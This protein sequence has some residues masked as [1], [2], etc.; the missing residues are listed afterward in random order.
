MRRAQLLE[1]VAAVFARE[2]TRGGDRRRSRR[3]PWT[4][5][6]APAAATRG[7]VLVVDDNPV[8]R[9]VMEAMLPE[10]GL[11]VDLAEDGGEALIMLAPRHLAVFMDCQMPNIDGYEA[12]ARI[13]AGQSGGVR[14]PIIAMTAHA[15]EGDRERC[16]R[17]GM[18]DY[19]S[20][21]LRSEDLDAVIE[22]WVRVAATDGTAEAGPLIDEARVRSFNVDYRSMA[23]ELWTVFYEATPP[24]IGEL[25]DAVERG[26]ADECRRL[27]H[28]LK[29]S[30]E[31]VGATR[32][33][34]LSR[35][36]EQGGPATAWPWSEELET[37][38]DRTRDEL[39]RLAALA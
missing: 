33:A 23:E 9:V 38:Y 12:T 3:R 37:A 24:L 7:R 13:R 25:R 16:L 14:V 6:R 32:M 5:P 30:S 1:A 26:D 8:N 21:P 22:R 4:R 11:A 35:A 20:K 18:D 29:G 15:L 39:L 34:T 36:L 17:A 31:T 2:P 10:R 19:L 28:K 27:A